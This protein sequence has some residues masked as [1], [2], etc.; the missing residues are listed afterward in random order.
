MNISAE[1]E[2]DP[3]DYCLYPAQCGVGGDCSECNQRRIAE[4]EA[5]CEVLEKDAERLDWLDEHCTRALN[6]ERYL[7]RQVYWGRGTHRD[8]RKAIDE[9]K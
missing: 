5:R 7:P 6:G 1:F 4:L 3:D 2:M 8:I 9:V